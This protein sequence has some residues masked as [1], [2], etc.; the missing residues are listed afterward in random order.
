MKK[1]LVVAIVLMMIGIS[2]GPAAAWDACTPGY[3][4]NHPEMW[5]VELDSTFSNVG[6]AATGYEDVELMVAL[7]YGG[8]PGDE[9]AAK[10]LLR[11]AAATYLNLKMWGTPEEIELLSLNLS[12]SIPRGRSTMLHIAEIYDNLNNEL[13][14][15]F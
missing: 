7:N 8:G 15:P 3:W 13:P 10:I 1:L 4:K 12:W 2:I 5:P 11:T 14:C 6:L 9:G